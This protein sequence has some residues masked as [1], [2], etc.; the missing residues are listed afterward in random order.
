[1]SKKYKLAVGLIIL[2]VITILILIFLNSRPLLIF[3]G[4]LQN[5][6]YWLELAFILILVWIFKL[7]SQHILYPSFAIIALGAILNVFTLDQASEVFLRISFVG[8]LVG[9]TLTLLENYKRK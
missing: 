5:S 3:G 4:L 8:L 6:F 9:V 7:K 1:M 2:L